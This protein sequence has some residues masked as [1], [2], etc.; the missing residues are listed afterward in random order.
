MHFSRSFRGCNLYQHTLDAS[1]LFFYLTKYIKLNTSQRHISIY[2]CYKIKGDTK[3]I[4]IPIEAHTKHNYCINSFCQRSCYFISGWRYQMET[5]S[6]LLALCAG[7]S[8]VSGE[9]PTQRPVTRSLDILFDLRLKKLLSK[10][11]WGW[12]F[13]TLSSPLWR[14]F[15][16]ML[17]RWTMKYLQGVYTSKFAMLWLALFYHCILY[18]PPAQ[19]LL[20]RQ[21]MNIV[22][23]VTHWISIEVT[24]WK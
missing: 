11:P 22:K 15:N 17:W 12:W 6:A 14:H 4:K 24:T 1:V 20:L 7:S 10:Q 21:Y 2:S 19:G 9:F 8:P 3:V 5:F 23:V 18:M 16:V 13:E